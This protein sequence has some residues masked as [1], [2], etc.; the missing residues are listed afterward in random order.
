MRARFVGGL[1]CMIS[2]V[3]S[4]CGGPS[5]RPVS[6]SSS[7]PSSLD[8]CRA[9]CDAGEGKACWEVAQRLRDGTAHRHRYGMLVD[10]LKSAANGGR[11]EAYLEL[12]RI[13]ATGLDARD[14]D[15]VV[16]KVEADLDLAVS[17]ARMGCDRA[18]GP[19]CYQEALLIESSPRPDRSRAELA[20]RAALDRGEPMGFAAYARLREASYGEPVAPKLDC[21]DD[22]TGLWLGQTFAQSQGR[23][24]E[25]ALRIRSSKGA[26]TGEIDVDHWVGPLVLRGESH[27]VQKAEGEATDD[28]MRFD[29]TGFASKEHGSY[30]LD[31]LRGK[32]SASVFVAHNEDTTGVVLGGRGFVAFVRVS[33][34]PALEVGPR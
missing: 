29:A 30:V 32:R 19:A 10:R 20:Y 26:L 7:C 11:V 5:P 15:G 2:V 25:M 3:V 9:S 24:Y 4:A 16:E 23:W 18:F 34:D 33:C 22:T 28:A 13:Y 17:F 6:A 1:F 21:T 27:V 14:S 8:A 12:A 31:K